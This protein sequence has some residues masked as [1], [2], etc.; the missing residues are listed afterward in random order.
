M[1]LEVSTLFSVPTLLCEHDLL[2]CEHDLLEMCLSESVLHH[3]AVFLYNGNVHPTIP[4]S[5][6]AHSKNSGTVEA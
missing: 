6:F 4:D 2:L 5:G 3:K 1:T